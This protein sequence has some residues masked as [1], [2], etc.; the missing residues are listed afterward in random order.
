M[1][2]ILLFEAIGRAAD[3][4]TLKKGGIADEMRKTDRDTLI[5]RVQ[6]NDKGDNINFVHRMA[7]HQNG[8]I[9]IVWPSDAATGTMNFPRVPW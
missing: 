9:A 3:K 4:G 6:F 8:K 5:G 7:Q 1:Q 2:S